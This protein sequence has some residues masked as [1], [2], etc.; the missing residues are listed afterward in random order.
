M[1]RATVP[2]AAV[3]EHSHSRWPEHDVGR[4][5]KGRHRP[6]MDPVP[7]PKAVKRL[8]HGELGGRV[9]R[10]LPLHLLPHL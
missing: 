7:Q 9:L 10:P 5:A 4:P 8:P 3:D 6:P 2:E 1:L